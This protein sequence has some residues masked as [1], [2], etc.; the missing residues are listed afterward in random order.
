MKNGHNDMLEAIGAIPFVFS[1][2]SFLANGFSTL[3]V[4]SPITHKGRSC[5]SRRN[6]F[7]IVAAVK[8]TQ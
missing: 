6:P 1:T 4:F 3:R 2:K 8:A 5:T 7:S